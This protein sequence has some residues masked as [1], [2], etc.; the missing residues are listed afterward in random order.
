MVIS[1]DI[2]AVLLRYFYSS[3]GNLI[4]ITVFCC[5]KLVVLCSDKFLFSFSGN[6]PM[7]IHQL[8]SEWLP[9]MPD[10][11]EALQKPG[12]CVADVGCGQGFSAIEMARNFPNATVDGYDLDVASIE[13]AKKNLEEEGESIKSRITFQCI[14]AH[15]AADGKRKYDLITLFQCFH[16]MSNPGEILTHL[17]DIL[18][19]KP[20]VVFVADQWN[21]ESLCDVIPNIGE[22]LNV[23]RAQLN[24]AASALHCVPA[25]MMYQPTPAYGAG[26]KGSTIAKLADEAG[27]TCKPFHENKMF[28]FYRLDLK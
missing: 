16:D 7:Y 12:A 4:I 9:K 3:I 17:R 20:G 14:P 11:L 27:F 25:T 1:A 10:V 28:R 13:K 23:A 15:L 21:A 8:A 18:K 24:F 6:R 5:R 19:P 26:I 22:E 2:F